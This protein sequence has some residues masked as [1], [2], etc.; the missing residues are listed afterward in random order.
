[1]FGISLTPENSNNRNPDRF[2]WD[3]GGAA[4][5]NIWYLKIFKGSF[6]HFQKLENQNLFQVMLH[7]QTKA[8]P[9]SD[10]SSRCVSDVGGEAGFQK[11]L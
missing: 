11:N 1:M 10:Q 6:H 2:I 3:L 5:W 8:R 9:G 4:L 7:D